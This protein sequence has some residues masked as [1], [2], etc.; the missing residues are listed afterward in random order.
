[1]KTVE[2]KDE[3]VIL[4]DQTLLP[5]ELKYIECKNVECVA[6]AIKSLR[7]RG[8]PAIG[9]TAALALALVAEQN[10]EKDRREILKELE[11]A[12]DLLAETRPTAVNLFLALEKITKKAEA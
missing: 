5:S 9:V 2:Y 7:V 6:E 8:A 11:K 10:Q 4:V 3:K 12:R 1:M